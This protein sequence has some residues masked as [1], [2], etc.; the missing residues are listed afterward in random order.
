MV[1][2]ATALQLLRA[3]FEVTVLE[4]RT[5]GSG[6]SRGNCGTITP[7]H[8][9]PL[10]MPGA[11]GTALRYLWRPDAPFYVKPRLDRDLAAWLLQFAKR[12][13]WRDF[14][15]SNRA[16]AVLLLYARAQLESCI[17]QERLD[18]GFSATGTLYLFRDRAAFR[19]VQW[20]PRALADAGVPLEAWDGDAIRAREPCVA[21]D[22]VAGFFNPHDAHLQPDRYVDALAARVRALGGCIVEGARIE[23]LHAES[24][25]IGDVRTA[26]GRYVGKHVILALGASSPQV[27]RT[28]GLRVPIQPGKGYSLTYPRPPWAPRIPMV[29]K[30]RSV[31]V[32]AWSDGLRL[33][34]TMEFSGYDD[35]LN[36]RRLQALQRA[37]REY[38]VMPEPLSEGQPW[39]GWRAMTYDDL[40]IIGRSTRYDNL[41]WATGHG[42]MGVTLSVAT[43]LIVRDLLAG[44]QPEIPID[45]YAPGRFSL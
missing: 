8:A 4:G 18:C 17:A 5:L 1:G 41:V 7:S 37:A 43:A 36:L 23:S 32:T 44:Q 25:R 20:L 19:A 12:C 21:Q 16:R 9:P 29:L 40:P 24:G 22:V 11:V 3:G 13:N 15:E 14:G 28:L 42:M 35:T 30:E 34:S 6:A 10:A 39:F 26:V 45:A 31:C 33:G 27:A 38:L 2:L